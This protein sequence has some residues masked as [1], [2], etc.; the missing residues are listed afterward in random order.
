MKISLKFQEKTVTATLADNETAHDF[1]SLLPLTMT[2]NDLFQREKF[3]HLPRAISEAGKPTHTYEVGDL[4][5]WSP[6]P[7]L[8]VFYRHDGQRI[9]DPGVIVIGKLDA[10]AEALDVP[11][12]VKVT[13]ELIK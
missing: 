5:Y 4:I 1:A 11:G 13:F 8:A 10:G 12:P 9:P 3:G 6:G 7:D 2:M